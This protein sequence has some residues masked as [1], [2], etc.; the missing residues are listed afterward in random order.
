MSARSERDLS[1]AGIADAVPLTRTAH[2]FALIRVLYGRNAVPLFN[3]A[4]VPSSQMIR[5]P[6]NFTPVQSG[7]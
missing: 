5:L 4:V 6:R 3:Q 1:A 7:F 2:Y